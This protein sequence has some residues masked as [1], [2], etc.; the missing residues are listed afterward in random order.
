M[1]DD[2]ATMSQSNV[3]SAAVGVN[4]IVVN[5]RQVDIR[6]LLQDE[7]VSIDRVLIGAPYLSQGTL[8]VRLDPSRPGV[9]VLVGYVTPNAWLKAEEAPHTTLE[10]STPAFAG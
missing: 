1:L 6:P 9:G 5:G 8:V 2:S 3:L 10:S 4:D 7:T